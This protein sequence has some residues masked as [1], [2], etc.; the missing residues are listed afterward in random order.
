MPID[1]RSYVYGG[2][3]ALVQLHERHLRAFVDAWEHAVEAGTTLP[4]TQDPTCETL[5][6]MLRHVLG[7]ARR[8]MLWICANLGLPDPGIDPIPEDIER[9]ARAYLEHV[10]AGWDGPLCSLDQRTLDQRT[11]E[12]SWGVPYCID[13]MLEHAVMHPIRHTLQLERAVRR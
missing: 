3:R 5:E 1:E 6:A 7:A 2:A 8:Y 11:F 12:S 4:P 13:A 10:L 9:G